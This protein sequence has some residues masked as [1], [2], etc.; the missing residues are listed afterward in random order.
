MSCKTT[1]RH[2]PYSAEQS[3][4]WAEVRVTRYS[5]F[6]IKDGV[7]GN[8]N[9]NGIGGTSGNDRP[10]SKINSAL[11]TILI[12]LGVYVGAL[13]LVGLIV[14]QYISHKN[15]RTEEKGKD[16]RVYHGTTEENGK[17]N[18]NRG[19]QI[20]GTDSF[21][22]AGKTSNPT[23]NAA[24]SSPRKSNIIGGIGMAVGGSAYAS[25]GLF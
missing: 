3:Q 6:D 12:I 14:T 18:G 25:T 21:G 17:R 9:G 10:E 23:S 19:I 8:G 1:S 11:Q 2:L 7:G 20:D 16:K 24:T 13:L 15:K 22:G 5:S 4:N